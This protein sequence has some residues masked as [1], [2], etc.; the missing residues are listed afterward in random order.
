MIRFLSKYLIFCGIFIA[1]LTKYKLTW[2]SDVRSIK[3]A[4]Y[5][6]FI[7]YCNEIFT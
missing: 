5:K 3:N 1:K 6:G 2:F 7:N 4:I